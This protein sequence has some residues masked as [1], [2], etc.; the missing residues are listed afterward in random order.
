[1]VCIGFENRH[2]ANNFYNKILRKAEAAG[3]DALWEVQR[4]LARKDLF[5]LLTRV[6]NRP[7]IDDDWLF[8][9]CKEVQLNPDGILDLWAR[10]H[11]KSTVITFGYTIMELM[12]DPDLTFGIFSH[13]RPIAKGFLR[14]IKTEFEDNELLKWLFP[15]ILWEKPRRDA[16]KWSED[17]GIILKRKSNKKEATVEAW[18]LVDGQPTSKHFDR[19]VYDDVVTLESVRSPEM[20]KK[21]TDSWEVSLNLGVRPVK[22][23]KI[24]YIGTRYNFADTYAVMIKRGIPTRL[25]PAT[26]TGLPEGNPIFMTRSE[27]QAKRQLMGSYTY[28][29]QMLQNPVAD[30]AQNFNVDWLRYYRTKPRLSDLH[31]YILVDPAGA[32]KKNSDYTVMLV[33]GLAADKNYYLLDGIRDRLS[34]TE[35]T[36]ELFRL[37]RLYRPL[38]VGYEKYGKDSD[39]EHIEYVQDLK[40]YHFDI[41]ACGGLLAKPDRIRQLVPVF[42][43]G[44]FF[45]PNSL[46]FRTREMRYV[47]LVQIFVNDE[48]I[49]FPANMT[50][51]DIFDCMARIMSPELEAEFPDSYDDFDDIPDGDAA[52]DYNPLMNIENDDYNPITGRIHRV[53]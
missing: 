39:I 2:E 16:P 44:R 50:H 51:D 36:N 18:G 1:M 33:I 8:L 21:T 41:T 27:L 5:Y 9:R 29:C 52:D 28:A 37:H 24:R 25:H 43:F 12:N 48:Y 26:D 23:G 10:E 34:L 14:Q 11:Y 15:D 30:D 7:D 31:T 32:K 40:T 3:E 19:L 22:G 20:I 38:N 17:D 42:E 4:D 6:L 13:T 47:D 49:T 45:L 46:M 53:G 35:R